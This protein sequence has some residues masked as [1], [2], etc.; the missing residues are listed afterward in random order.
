MQYQPLMIRSKI[1]AIVAQARDIEE[2]RGRDSGKYKHLMYK[3]TNLMR[4]RE[5]VQVSN[6]E[7]RRAFYA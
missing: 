5:V 2:Q 6:L 1:K 3:A 4:K 7:R